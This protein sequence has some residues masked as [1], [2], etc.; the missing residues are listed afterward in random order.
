MI[1]VI[2]K[3][4]FNMRILNKQNTIKFGHKKQLL[5]NNSETKLVDYSKLN[6]LKFKKVTKLVF[7]EKERNFIK[8]NAINLKKYA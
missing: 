1:D 5:V 2:H 7:Q 3:N 4:I 8:R 6:L